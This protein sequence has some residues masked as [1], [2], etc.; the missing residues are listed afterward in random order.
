MYV[1]NYLRKKKIRKVKSRMIKKR[2]KSDIYF[3]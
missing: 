2:K 3:Y 1:P